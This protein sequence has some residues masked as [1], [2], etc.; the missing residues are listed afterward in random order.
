MDFYCH[1]AKLVIEVDGAF[2]GEQPEADDARTADL[3]SAGHQVLRFGTSAILSDLPGVL[4]A[5]LTVC[6][7]HP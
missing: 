2:H 1:E 6:T 3:E 5:I 7:P 4:R